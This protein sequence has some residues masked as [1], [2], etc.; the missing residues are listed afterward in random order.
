M[1]LLARL[2]W[3]LY[4]FG[5]FLVFTALRVARDHATDVDP[6]R[7]PLLRALRRVMPITPHL[8]GQ[9]LFA[10][11]DGRRAATP[12]LVALVLIE[13]TDIVFAVDSVPAILAISRDPFVVISS[14][15]MAILGLRA[16]YFLL[17][18]VRSR[19]VYLN[20]GLAAILGFV[21]VKMVI[22]RFLHIPATISLA[23]IG[24]ILVITVVASL[25]RG[26]VDEAD[27]GGGGAPANPAGS[28]SESTGT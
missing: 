25:L 16:L 1:A 22:S 7:N 5:G 2:E 3:L 21:G 26:G 6:E 14:N 4:V 10:R 15:A 28:P 9:R 12:L 11:V 18:G 13:A 27:P 8:H 23:V 20:E 24:G 19:L 17:A